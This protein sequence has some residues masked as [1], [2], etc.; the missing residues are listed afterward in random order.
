VPAPG[1]GTSAIADAREVPSVDAPEDR[2]R[3]QDLLSC[4]KDRRGSAPRHDH[5]GEGEDEPEEHGHEQDREPPAGMVIWNMVRKTRAVD[6]GGVVDV[7]QDR[8]EPAQ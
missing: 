3:G 5:I 7:L 1:R 6:A 2:E 8:A 4:R